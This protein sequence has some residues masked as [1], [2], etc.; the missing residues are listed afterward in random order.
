V[1]VDKAAAGLDWRPTVALEAGLLE[2]YAW[3]ARQRM[4][5]PA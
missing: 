2:T 3:F 5:I 4:G 1:K